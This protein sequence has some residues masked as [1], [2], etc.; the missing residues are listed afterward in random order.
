MS[1]RLIVNHPQIA[2][3]VTSLQQLFHE[4]ALRSHGYVV[5]FNPDVT[6]VQP[7]LGAVSLIIYQRSARASQIRYP[8]CCLAAGTICWH[9]RCL[10]DFSVPWLLVQDIFI[11][12]SLSVLVC[13]F[14]DTA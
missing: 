10:S 3:T 2:V 4:L 5:E 9:T 6:C 14:N 8:I 11:I 1:C 7:V 13:L 12:A